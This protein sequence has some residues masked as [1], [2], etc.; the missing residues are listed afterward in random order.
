[1]PI[2]VEKYIACD[3]LNGVFYLYVSALISL[4]PSGRI[5]ER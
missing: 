2:L 1:M 3:I 4:T 5:P